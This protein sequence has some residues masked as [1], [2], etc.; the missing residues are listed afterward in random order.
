NVTG[1]SDRIDI[2]ESLRLLKEVKP[3]L[4]KL[5]YLYNAS[6]AN[7]VSTLKMLKDVADKIGID[8]IPSSAPKPSDVQMATRALIGK[9]DVIFIPADNTVLSVLEGATKVTQEARI[10]LFTVD[11]NSM[12]RGPFMTQ[13]VNFYDVGVDAGK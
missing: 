12:G 3:D 13:G 8:V 10:P 4:K 11:S 9:V 6:E 5:G 1:T 7:S 2:A